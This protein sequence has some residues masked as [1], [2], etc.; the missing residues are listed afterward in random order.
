MGRQKKSLVGI[1][2]LCL[3]VL[4][5]I[6]IT[7]NQAVAD[8]VYYVQDTAYTTASRPLVMIDIPE[9]IKQ[10]VDLS[11][12]ALNSSFDD[13]EEE[14]I[15]Y[16]DKKFDYFH[17]LLKN[18]TLEKQLDYNHE[19]RMKQLDLGV[20]V[21]TP[22]LNILFDDYYTRDEVD[23]LISD[24]ISSANPPQAKTPSSL[25][26]FSIK[27]FFRFDVIIILIIVF[28]IGTFLY[29]KKQAKDKEIKNIVEKYPSTG[30]RPDVTPDREFLLDQKIKNVVQ[31]TPT[32][33]T[34]QPSSSSKD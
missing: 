4:I 23:F 20:N 8:H 5:I 13:I 30:S 11:P 34:N 12:Y 19:Y 21:T 17:S 33:H 18:T 9:I 24:F 29:K 3:I 32:Q 1:F 14:L 31:Q 27:D 6:L 25:S 16:V 28:W 10:K 15:F 7:I 22:E 26:S 2:L